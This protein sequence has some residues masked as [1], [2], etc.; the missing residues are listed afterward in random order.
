MIESIKKFFG[1]A[2]LLL[3]ITCSFNLAFFWADAEHSLYNLVKLTVYIVAGSYLFW[4]YWL[5][6]KLIAIKIKRR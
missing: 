6:S 4:I 3:A 2:G 5:K 1:F